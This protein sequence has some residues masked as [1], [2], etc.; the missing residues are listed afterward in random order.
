M[1]SGRK[2]CYVV[3]FIT[4]YPPWT[5][6]WIEGPR[7][8]VETKSTALAKSCQAQSMMGKLWIP[9]LILSKGNFPRSA[10]DDWVDGGNR[11]LANII[12]FTAFDVYK[13]HVII[14]LFLCWRASHRLMASF[15]GTRTAIFAE[16]DAF[17]TT[18]SPHFS[19]TF[20]FPKAFV[21]FLWSY[22]GSVPLH[23]LLLSFLCWPLHISFVG[24]LT[25]GVLLGQGFFRFGCQNEALL[26][27]L[28]LS[29]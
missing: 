5:R 8:A 18:L 3:L 21:V 28:A 9:Y 6:K 16:G 2:S 15:H 17:I 22:D 23:S 26:L 19:C 27:A 12:P 14:S 7:P 29:L 20:G 24:Q 11:K 25:V 1:T 13:R 10:S 4:L